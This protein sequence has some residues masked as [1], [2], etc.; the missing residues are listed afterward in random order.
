MLSHPEYVPRAWGGDSLTKRQK[1][2]Q[3]EEERKRNAAMIIEDKT[4]MEEEASRNDPDTSI[5]SS[6]NIRSDGKLKQLT[7]EELKRSRDE[8]Q[9][10]WKSGGSTKTE[11]TAKSEQKKSSPAEKPGTKKTVPDNKLKTTGAKDSA[12]HKNVD[13]RAID[14]KTAMEKPTERS[15]DKAQRSLPVQ[16]KE[17]A[18]PVKSSPARKKEA[19]PPP[20]S[21]TDQ[22]KQSPDKRKKIVNER[23]EQSKTNMQR[24]TR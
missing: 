18:P 11:A 21:S 20:R 9:K 2:E 19:A 16:K 8:K 15:K 17:A 10:T 5:I 24:Q 4:I 12:E 14:M 7:M 1:E 23:K 3:L 13:Q 22:Q 6:L